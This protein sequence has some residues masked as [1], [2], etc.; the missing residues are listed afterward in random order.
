MLGHCCFV[1]YSVL[2]LEPSSPDS[3]LFPASSDSAN[4]QNPAT[5]RR[6]PVEPVSHPGLSVASCQKFLW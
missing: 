2:S 4:G 3:L 1:L 5:G 6:V